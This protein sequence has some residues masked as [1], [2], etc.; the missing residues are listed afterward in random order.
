MPRRK[1]AATVDDIP[2]WDALIVEFGDPRPHEPTII[3]AAYTVPDDYFLDETISYD[4]AFAQ[5]CRDAH[6][7]FVVLGDVHQEALTAL[8]TIY[9]WPPPVDVTDDAVPALALLDIE[10]TQVLP[11]WPSD[12]ESS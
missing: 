6:A 1:V 12:E 2:L 5:L 11:V 4:T 9:A 10:S 8:D 3:D 7:V